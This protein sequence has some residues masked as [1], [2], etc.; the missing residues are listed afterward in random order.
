MVDRLVLSLRYRDGSHSDE[1]PIE[2]EDLRSLVSQAGVRGGYLVAWQVGGLALSFPEEALPD[3][4]EL[5]ADPCCETMQ[6]GL[7]SGELTLITELGHTAAL[8]VG[9]SL[10]EGAVLSAMAQPGEVLVAPSVIALAPNLL[11][12]GSRRGTWRGRRWLRAER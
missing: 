9:A 2:I 6:A 12:V 11:T 8:A 5:L 1:P 4:V 7:A 3:V 10:I